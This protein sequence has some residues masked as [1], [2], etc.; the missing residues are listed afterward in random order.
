MEEAP[1]PASD[2]AAIDGVADVV[3][4]IDPD[5]AHRLRFLLELDRLKGILRRSLVLAG[6]RR[7]NSAEHS[8]HLALFAIVLAPYAEEPVD[9]ARVVT[10]L[11]L[12]DVVEI[13]AGDTYIYDKAA[14]ERKAEEEHQAAQRIYG[15]LP[16]DEGAELRGL[17]EEYERQDTADSR[18]AHSVD[19]LQ[20][21]L[22]NLVSGA[23]SWHQHGVPAS[24]V[25]EINSRMATGSTEL[26]TAASA[27]IDDAITR[28]ILTP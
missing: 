10:M 25:R 20:P 1:P 22:L 19:R 7:E 18:F 6:E 14:V 8:W 3:G 2:R 13:D 15:L 11:L 16:G 23:V 26:W 9:L 12:H 24:R 21:L 5:L 4:G 17:W 27:L 28:G